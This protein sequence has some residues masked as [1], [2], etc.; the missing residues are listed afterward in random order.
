LN[1]FNLALVTGAT[2][3]IGEALAKLLAD[4]G[5]SLLLTGRN[6]SKLEEMK[7]LLE[8]EVKVEIVPADLVSR[9]DRKK[10]IQKIHERQVDLLI[11][12][13]GFGL[14]GP[15]ISNETKI[16]SDMIEVDITAVMELT[17][18]AAKAMERGKYKGVILN[19]SSA[20]AFHILP[21]MAVYS[22]AKAFVNSFSLTVD[23][24]LRK[25]GIRVLAACP[26]RVATEFQSRASERK[27]SSQEGGLFMSAEF[28]AQQIW[29]QI[30]S[31]QPI[32]IFDWRYRMATYLSY[33][34]PR[35]LSAKIGAMWMKRH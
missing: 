14:Y 28:A 30:L 7:Q 5:I 13:A 26:G 19:V 29:Y 18:E 35:E 34:V 27:K 3:G 10:I 33:L 9:E 4:K 32:H 23:I 11:N 31:Q 21:N 12:N 25:K 24:E 6:Q 15:A 16:Y 20:A 2:S 22:A 17:L 8:P 1:K